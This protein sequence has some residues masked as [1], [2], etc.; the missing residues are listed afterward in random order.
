VIEKADH[1][2]VAPVAMGWSDVGS[3]DALHAI[4]ER[5]AAGNAHGSGGGEVI[6]IDTRDC[7][8]RTDGPRVALVGVENLIVVASGQDILILPRGRSQ[9]VKALIEAM[10]DRAAGPAG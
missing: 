2:A 5:D 1:V 4:S 6:A 10:K 9:E 7:L 8:V 3:W